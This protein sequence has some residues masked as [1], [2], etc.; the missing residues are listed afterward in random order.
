MNRRLFAATLVL[1]VM[2]LALGVMALP[3]ELLL[4]LVP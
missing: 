3:A 4:A 2:I 1:A